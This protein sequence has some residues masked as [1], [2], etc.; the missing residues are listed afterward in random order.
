MVA[1]QQKEWKFTIMFI[2]KSVTKNK[3]TKTEYIT[4]KLV[5][6]YRNKEGQVRQRVVM[7][8]GI[9]DLPKKRWPELASLLEARITGQISFLESDDDI[10][11]IADISLKH[12]EFV[13]RKVVEEKKVNDSADVE[14]IDLNSVSS[15]YNRSLG[16]ELVANKYWEQLEFERIL[17]ECYFNQKQI[18]IS[19]VLIL[20]RLINPGSELGTFNW[21]NK[22]TSLMEMTKEDLI[23]VGKDAFYEVGDLLFENKEKIEQ[24]LSK[25]EENFFGPEK[26]I[27]LYDLTNTYIEGSGKN[28]DKAQRG[29]SKEKRSDCP[30]VTLALVVDKYGFP[31]FSQI[32]EGNVSEPQT[33][34]DILNRLENDSSKNS[35]TQKPVLIMDR[36]IATK[37]NIKL[38]DDK[39]EYTVIN[40]AKDEEK[41]AAEFNVIKEF[42]KDKELIIEENLVLP[43]KWEK[44]SHKKDV[45]VKKII[46]E[47]NTAKVLTLS[48]KKSLKEKS[49]DALKEKRFLEDLEKLN[50]SIKKGNIVIP[51]KIGERIGKIK[52]KYS[53][54]NKFYNIEIETFKDNNGRVERVKCEKKPK[55][56]ERLTLQGCYIIETTQKGLSAAEIWNQYMELNHVENS[57]RD[58]KS[59]L[60]IRPIYHSKENRTDAHLF[61]SVLAYHILNTIEYNLKTD[62]DNRTWK[63]IKEVLSTH[64]R[65]T[66]ILKN[67]NK[68]TFYIRVS[69]MPESEHN[70]IY[71][72]LKINDK[73]KRRNSKSI[74]SL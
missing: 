59:E 61:I 1:I 41:Y 72:T 27:F 3:K 63:T 30:I 26:R 24:E 36:G 38:I 57:F 13:K 71:R 28:N 21:F 42:I 22:R 39:Y 50:I 67:K 12:N 51:S 34:I 5:E 19:K 33:F 74:Q 16:P 53:S 73:L 32:Y 10:A 49:M 4:H 60:G 66:I 18:D 15:S 40:R 6:S 64:Q 56:V 58:L 70:E 14:E 7:S 43:D 29:R 2:R 17:R 20:G 44:I 35:F 69:G 48:V 23:N 52:T 54:C 62:G 37:N 25:I 45:F 31:L 65:S 8:L 55:S 46:D 11:K 47:E 9:I 68:K